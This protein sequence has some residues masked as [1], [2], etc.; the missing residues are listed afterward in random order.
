MHAGLSSPGAKLNKVCNIS[1]CSKLNTSF[2]S[3]TNNSMTARIKLSFAEAQANNLVTTY[4]DYIKLL[5][6]K[7]EEL[8][9]DVLLLGEK[10]EFKENEMSEI[11]ES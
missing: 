6:D 3:K 9:S 7:V 8:E 1:L 5:E 10:L 11:L 4:D 2:L